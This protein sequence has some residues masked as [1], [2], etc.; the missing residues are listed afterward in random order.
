M[1]QSR[2]NSIPSGDRAAA[3]QLLKRLRAHR[4]ARNWTQDEMAKRAGMSR[5]TYQ[6]FEGG[7]GN[8][9]L[10][11]LMRILGILGFTDRIAE[12]V[13]EPAEPQTLESLRARTEPTERVRASRKR[14]SS[15]T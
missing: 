9:T 6:N 3:Q 8:P 4:L 2:S 7:Y 1:I 13:P 14:T 11:N 10:S 12:L 15:S 5:A